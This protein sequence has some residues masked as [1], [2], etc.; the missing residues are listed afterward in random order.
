VPVSEGEDLPDVLPCPGRPDWECVRRGSPAHGG[1]V[2]APPPG[3]AGEGQREGL[4]PEGY[5]P[6]KRHRRAYDLDGKRI[7]RPD[8]DG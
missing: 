7:V 1:P 5:V 6:R 3:P 4:C 2:A 8:D